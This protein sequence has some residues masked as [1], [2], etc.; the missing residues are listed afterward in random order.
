VAIYPKEGTLF[1]DNPLYILDSPWVTPEQKEAARLF[2]EFVQLPEN[3]QK[4]LAF[5]FRPGNAA[6]PIGAPIVAE[7]GVDPNQP[8]AV[9]DVPEPAVLTGVLD[10]WAEDRKSAAVMVVMDVS[11]SM[12]DPAVTGGVDTKLDLAKRAAIESLDEFKDTDEV[13]LRIFSTGLPST[14]EDE[15]WLDLVPV[16]PMSENREELRSAIENLFPVEGTPLY[17]VTDGSYAFM[18]ERFDPERINAVVLLTDGVNDD[19]FP[20][21]DAAELDALLTSLQQGSEGASTDEVRVFPI[22]YGEGA[23]FA[24]LRRIAEATNAAVYD[25]SNPNTIQQ[26]FT[27]V[28]SNC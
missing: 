18:K 3:Q 11:G 10:N 21:D 1:S 14:T 6:V 7:N 8:Q 17:A 12:G 28:V 16:R 15:P 25:A 9:L 23:D 2:E 13:G 24:T 22:A 26:V 20:D 27:A 5:G 4:V 19:G